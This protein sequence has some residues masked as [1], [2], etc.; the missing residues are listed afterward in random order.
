[1]NQ[2]FSITKHIKYLLI[3]VPFLYMINANGQGG[4][5][6]VFTLATPTLGQGELSY[7]AMVMTTKQNESAWMLRQNWH[8]GLTEDIQLN[9]SVP[10]TL[11]RI[12][13]PPQGRLGTMMGSY[14]D[15][16]ISGLFRV[17]KTYPAIGQRFESTLLLGTSLP[18]E[19]KRGGIT[20]GPSIHA[21]TVTG[22]ASRSFY[23]WAGTGYQHYFKKNNDQLGNIFYITGVVGYR[24]AFFQH[25]YPKPDWRIFLESVTEWVGN[26]TVDNIE[27]KNTDLVRTLL[28]PSVL[29]LYGKW[30]LSAG[31]LFPLDLTTTKTDELELFRSSFVLSYWF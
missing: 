14:G 21:A 18:T 10:T 9:F 30:G 7:D 11:K 20:V 27:N 15:L 13:N 3:L 24:P 23:A 19:S 16:E 12:A 25:D 6:P 29:G 8:Y 4:H 17:F 31:I 26:N 2:F 22:Y 28:G 1:M 5:G